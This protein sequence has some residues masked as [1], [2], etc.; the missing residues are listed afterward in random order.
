MSHT[1]SQPTILT[2]VVDQIGIIT[3]NRPERRNA[4]NGYL[5]KA[6]EE[7][8]QDMAA[9]DDAKIVI[10]TGAQGDGMVGGFCSGGDIKEGGRITAAS[11]YA[12]TKDN[13]NQAEDQIERRRELF[14][15]E[16]TNQIRSGTD[17]AARMKQ[18][19]AAQAAAASAQQ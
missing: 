11:V 16:A 9:N 15:I 2:E 10:L 17:M 5:I 3:L 14:A 13:L 4:L 18:R 19:A 12:L 1:S 6:L 7:A 8:V